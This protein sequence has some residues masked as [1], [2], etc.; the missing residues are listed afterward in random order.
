MTEREVLQE[1]QSR[2]DR[3]PQILLSER[4]IRKK[5]LYAYT[6]LHR[7]QIQQAINAGTFPKPV[8]VGARIVAW[9]GSEIEEWQ[10]AR[11]AERDASVR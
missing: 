7:T 11:A 10:K 8:H 9:R 6:G 2:R 4:L 1:A 5:D 3:Q